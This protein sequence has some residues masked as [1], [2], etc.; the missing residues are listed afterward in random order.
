MMVE[1]FGF[2]VHEVTALL[3][4]NFLANMI[5]A[6]LM[7]KAVGKWGERNALA[8]EYV[9]LICV[10]LAY[11][12][13]YYFGWGVLVAATLYVLDHLFFALAV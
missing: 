3:L 12:G 11:G 5:F 6:P 13:V 2:E 9:G 4:I 1:K 10:F 8:F 7:G